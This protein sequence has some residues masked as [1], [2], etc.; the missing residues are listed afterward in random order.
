MGSVGLQDNAMRRLQAII[1]KQDALITELKTENYKLSQENV[2]LK[3]QVAKSTVE[4]K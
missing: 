2:D 1:D 3:I 4:K